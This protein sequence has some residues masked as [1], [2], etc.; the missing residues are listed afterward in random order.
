[1]RKQHKIDGIFFVSFALLV[2]TDRLWWFVQTYVL[3]DFGQ[4]R[5]MSI[6]TAIESLTLMIFTGYGGAWLD[7][8]CKIYSVKVL[9]SIVVMLSIFSHMAINSAY[10]F[11]HENKVNDISNN[12]YL[13][14]LISIITTSSASFFYNLLRLFLTKDWVVI[15]SEEFERK[16]FN[17][18]TLTSQSYENNQRLTYYN[19]VSALIYQ[20]SFIIEPIITGFI[21]N[22]L[23]YQMAATVFCIFNTCMWIIIYFLLNYIYINIEKLKR[24][25]ITS[26]ENEKLKNTCE[27]NIDENKNNEQ[28]KNESSIKVIKF[29]KHRVAYVA[30]ALSLT[31]MNILQL[32]GISITYITFNNVSEKTLNAFR[33]IG[34]VFALIGT[35]LYPLFNK[36][37]GL[38]K[39]G[40]IGFL[41]QQAFLVP[42][43]ISIFLPGSMF[44]YNIFSSNSFDIN[45]S[46][47]TFIIGITLSRF[48]LFIA[49]AA[50]NQQM[51]HM[52]EEENRSELFGIHTSLSYTCTLFSAGLLFLFPD[53]RD[54]GFFIILSVVELFCALI[55]Y[56]MHLYK[57]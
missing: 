51:Q 55:F 34:S 24:I 21:M 42:S 52:I 50:V 35:S 46:I 27:S 56:V 36:Y 20:I 8:H 11:K 22:Y 7:R 45:Y 17:I 43:F 57:I 53:P 49:D 13:S 23:N 12:C 33:C 16:K 44:K 30:I 25:K 9:L 32:S 5:L 31:Y 37:L 10:R 18:N 2:L 47:Y 28:W 4:F 38:K 3:S 29:L 39:T 19:T 6:Y 15:L 48:G 41:M 1:M 40:L 14:L 54:F 26:H